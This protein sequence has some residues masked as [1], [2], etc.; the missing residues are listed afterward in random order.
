MYFNYMLANFINTANLNSLKLQEYQYKSSGT[1]LSNNREFGVGFCGEN[2]NGQKVMKLHQRKFIQHKF[3]GPIHPTHEFEG[4]IP[5]AII[6][7]WKIAC[8]RTINDDNGGNWERCGEVIGTNHF[9]FIVTACF[10][11]DLNW[12]IYI[13]YICN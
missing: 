11:R 12:E 4:D 6:I 9:K 1:A 3:F 10:M 5:N 13:Y 2:Y 7:G 8:K